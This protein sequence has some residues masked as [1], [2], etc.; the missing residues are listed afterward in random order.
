MATMSYFCSG[1]PAI[2]VGSGAQPPSAFTDNFNRADENLE[3]SANWTHDGLIAGAVAVRSNALANL[4]SDATGS[5]YKCPDQGS[6]DHYV[7]FTARA[8]ANSGPFVCCRLADRSNF[9]GIR[10]NGGTLE[11]FRRVS[12]TLSSLHSSAQSIVSGTVLRLEC[13]GTNWRAL[14]D[15]AQVATGAIGSAGLT[16]QRQGV[17]G[18]TTITGQNPWIDNFEAGAL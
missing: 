18:R 17:V 9:V 11:I 10:N 1:S 5:A 13:T 7:Q 16:N 3:A 6:A 4:T 12:G 14:K 8:T 2:Y 15:G